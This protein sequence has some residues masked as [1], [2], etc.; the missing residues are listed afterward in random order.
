MGSREAR[1]RPDHVGVKGGE[2]EEEGGIRGW[3]RKLPWDSFV[4]RKGCRTLLDLNQCPSPSP[5]CLSL[6]ACCLFSFAS[7]L[8]ACGAPGEKKLS[9]LLSWFSSLT[10]PNHVIQTSGLGWLSD[11]CWYWL[12]HV[13]VFNLPTQLEKKCWCKFPFHCDVQSWPHLQMLRQ[14]SVSRYNALCKHFI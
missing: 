4:E 13:F 14:D 11:L 8:L 6:S 5:S 3:R 10:F 12:R 1:S 7:E 9:R 2:R